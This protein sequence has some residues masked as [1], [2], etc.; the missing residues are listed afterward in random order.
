[1]E[2]RRITADQVSKDFYLFPKMWI[3]YQPENNLNGNGMDD[4]NN[5]CYEQYKTKKWNY[6]YELKDEFL[7][8]IFNFGTDK[9]LSDCDVLSEELINILFRVYNEWE[10][11]KSYSADERISSAQFCYSYFNTNYN[12]GLDYDVYKKYCSYME[13]NNDKL[14]DICEKIF[15]S[16]DLKLFD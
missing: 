1:M 10:N 15:Y 12:L 2:I 6:I 16:Y 3:Y 9:K 14:E 7:G 13:Q 5:F 11:I 8:V 4:K